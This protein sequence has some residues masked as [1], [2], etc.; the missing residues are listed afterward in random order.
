MRPGNL[1]VDFWLK[2]TSPVIYVDVQPRWSVI[3]LTLRDH[4]LSLRSGAEP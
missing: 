1:M 3:Y 4:I 2:L